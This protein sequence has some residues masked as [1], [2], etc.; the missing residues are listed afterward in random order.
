MFSFSFPKGPD[1]FTD[2]TALPTLKI[3][4][5]FSL[6]KGSGS[7]AKAKSVGGIFLGSIAGT[8]SGWRVDMVPGGRLLEGTLR[9]KSCIGVVVLITLV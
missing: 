8:T 3:R 5:P 6:R 9:E 2:L 4:S 1:R 7:A